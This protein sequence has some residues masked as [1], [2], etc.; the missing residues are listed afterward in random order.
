MRPANS[1]S[2]FPALT[3]AARTAK[4][5]SALVLRNP[6][7]PSRKGSIR[8]PVG[9]MTLPG[10]E[11]LFVWRFRCPLPPVLSDTEEPKSS[12]YS[13]SASAA[14]KSLKRYPPRA[15]KPTLLPKSGRL[16]WKDGK[17]PAGPMPTYGPGP[18]Y[19]RCA[20]AETHRVRTIKPLRIV[21]CAAR[22]FIVASIQALPNPRRILRTP[23][24]KE[25]RYPT[26]LSSMAATPQRHAATHRAHT[27]QP[28]RCPIRAYGPDPTESRLSARCQLV[29][30]P[31]V[32]VPLGSSDK[33][34]AKSTT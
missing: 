4:F 28:M 12:M 11:K 8:V 32:P 20:L 34:L 2:D 31:F 1:V 21:M 22:L 29:H 26:V 27:D 17:P 10:R 15:L 7:P 14:R 6:T 30:V 33:A 18:V 3:C 13:Y 23:F 16:P 5:A 19:P 9:K 25:R 24:G